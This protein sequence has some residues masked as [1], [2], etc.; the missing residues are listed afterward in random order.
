MRI[1]EWLNEN[2]RRAR[3]LFANR[4]RF[5]QELDEEMRL[6]R[7]LRARE[8]RDEGA[9]AEQ[10]RLAAQRRFGN[11]LRLREDIH[12]AWGWNWIDNLRQDLGYGL[13]LLRKSPGFTFVVVLTLALAIGANTAIFSVVNAVLLQ[14][15]PYPHAEQLI[16]VLEDNAQKGTEANGFSYQDFETLQQSGIFAEVAGAQRHDLTL[17]GVGNPAVVTTVSVTPEMFPL[18]GVN[19]LKGRYFFSADNK[20]GAGAVVLLSEGLWR[21]R[22][23]ADPNILG[24]SVHLDQ[25]VFTVVGIMPG[26]FRVPIFGLHQEIWIPVVQDPLWGPWME[27]PSLHWVPVLGRL[28]P[29]VSLASVK[30]QIDALT[31]RLAQQF[32]AEDGGWTPRV[33]PL[34]AVIVG[35]MKAPLLVLLG[36]VALVLLLACVNIA[37]LLLARATSR[38][39]E[40]AVRQAFGAGRGRILRQFLTESAVLCFLGA[41]AGIALAYWGT[42][43]LVSF[44]PSDAP[45]TQTA[46]LDGRVVGFALL[47]S[48]AVSIGFGIA[49]A[50]LTAGIDVQSNL[51]SNAAQSGADRGGMRLRGLLT[52]VEI[53]LAMVLVAGAGLLGRSL[54]KMTSV[55]PGFTVSRVVKAEV[56]L[57]RYQYST[58]RQWTA[59]SE[60]LMERIQSQPGMQNSAFAVPLPLADT[61]VTLPIS[62]PNRPESAQKAQTAHYASVTQN[63]FRVMGIPL[64]RGRSFDR[65]DTDTRPHVALISESLAQMYFRDKNPIG[66]KISFGFG[67]NSP[68]FHEIVGVVGS[69]RDAG[70]SQEPG[71]MVYVPFAQEPLWGGMVTVRSTLPLSS[72]V[73]AIRQSVASIDKELPI[74]DI[75]TMSEVVDA[76]VAQPRFRTYLVSGFGLVALLLAAAGIF[77]I[78]SYSVASRTRE[79]GVRASLGATPANLS[80]MVLREGLVLACSGLAVGLV[81]ALALTRFL[82][83]QLYGVAAYDP[84]TLLVSIGALLVVALV[85]CYIPARRAMRVDPMIA[86][87]Y[88]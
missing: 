5:N 76:S 16:S 1:S 65:H 13:R 51:K 10:A 88:E 75:A 34:Q 56:S 57:P 82:K 87:R 8:L 29:G 49:P 27:K 61:P 55:N 31:R 30:S 11:T 2:L 4:E 71:P 25:R 72:V 64:L 39:R 36:A 80:R 6:H 26:S 67:P 47:L 18:L 78:V 12:E 73:G 17:T 3:M 60:V 24:R 15:L 35:E 23:G 48:L 84:G 70:L 21:N 58:P 50:L 52:R 79:F 66:E 41:I 53:A 22:F 77:G 83:G 7:E 43:A 19:P 40:V 85:A 81:A 42:Q 69:V 45:A 74:T 62:F 33:A 28:R 46:Q 20:K 54:I 59:F 68:V 14:P 38:I 32:P 9:H 37:N 44:L 86:L 63:Y